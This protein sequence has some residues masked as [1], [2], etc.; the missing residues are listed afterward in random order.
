MTLFNRTGENWDIA[1]IPGEYGLPVVG[2]S[3]KLIKDSRGFSQYMADRYGPVHRSSAF[4]RK[5]VVMLGPEANEFVLMDRDRNFSSEGGWNPLLGHLFPNGL[6]LRDFDNHRAHRKIMQAAFKSP[7]M[8][9]YIDYLNKGVSDRLDVWATHPDFNFYPAIKQL[10]LDLAASVFLGVPLGPEADRLNKAF[11]DS[12]AA[13]IA[14]VRVPIPGTKFGRGVKGRKYIQVYLRD[15]VPARRDGNGEDMFTLL[16]QATD[17]D[18]NRFTVDEIVDHMNFLMMAAHDTLTSSMTTMIHEL[19]QHNEWQDTLRQECRSVGL[20]PNLLPYD[21]LDDL[22]MMEWAFKETLRLNPPVPMIPRRT[23]RDVEFGGYKIP[24]NTSI[25][26]SPGHTHKMEEIWTNPENF[27][28]DRFSDQRAEDRKHK[29]SWVPFGGGSH[30]CIGLHFAYMQMKV[31][32]YQLMMKYE[33]YQDEGYEADFQIIPIPKP[34]DGMPI[35]I[36]PVEE[37]A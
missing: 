29:F 4:M 9:N 24:A 27:E 30:M 37:A 15:Q 18:G 21:K 16:C 36:R 23:I 26:I 28:P 10:T 19:A 5:T 12:V 1:H 13:A 32:M 8:R 14:V 25:T 11:A 20:S 22:Q 35:H 31:F 3:M 6:M 33:F 2:N 17:E 34:K 7:A